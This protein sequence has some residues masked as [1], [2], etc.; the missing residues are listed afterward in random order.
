MSKKDIRI[1]LIVETLKANPNISIKDLANKY[2]VSEMTIRRDLNYII[3]NGLFNRS[4]PYYNVKSDYTF[5][6]EQ[7]KHYEQKERIAQFAVSLINPED[8]IIIDSGTT[9]S[10]LAKVIPED[11]NITVLCYN[12][13]VLKQLHNKPNVSIIFAGGY[14]HPSD[15]MFESAEGVSLIQRIRANKMFVSA[16]GIHKELGITCANNYEVVTKRSALNSSYL[17]ILLADS[18]KFGTI[19]Q[20]YFAQLKDIDIIVTDN[21]LSSDWRQ[22]LTEQG[23]KLHF[24]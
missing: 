21:D 14:Y 20:G 5:S 11:I 10:L 23:I 4:N 13:Q 19:K 3:Q 12:Y 17:K 16:S 22:F 1:S 2:M 24:V 7:I 8:V 6:T 15:Q 18:S 9:T